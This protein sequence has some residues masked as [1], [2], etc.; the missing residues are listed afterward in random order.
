MMVFDVLKEYKYAM[1]LKL[2][3]LQKINFWIN[4]INYELYFINEAYEIMN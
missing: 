3:W 2:F 1:I 4:W